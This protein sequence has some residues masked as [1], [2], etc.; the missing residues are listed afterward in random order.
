M[1][2]KSILASLGACA[3]AMSAMALSASAAITNANSGENYLFPIVADEGNNLPEGCKLSDVYGFEAKF[4]K[5]AGENENCVGAFCWQSDS[6]NWAQHEFCQ[7]GGDK[8]VFIGSD[9]TV[10]WVSSEALFQDGDTWGKAFVAEWNWDKPD[11][12]PP[13]EDNQIDFSVVSFKLLDKDGNVLGAA[14]A[15]GNETTTTTTKANGGTTTKAANG[16]KTATTGAKTGDAGVGVAVGLLGLAG[17][18]AVVSRKKH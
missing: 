13:V 3:I 16:G 12:D 17:A 6:N 10:K 14:P 8:D 1:K 11:A 7:E 4:D 2:V 15:D 9:G 5:V 18:A